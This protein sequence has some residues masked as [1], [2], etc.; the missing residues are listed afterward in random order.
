MINAGK[1]KNQIRNCKSKAAALQALLVAATL[2]SG[3]GAP[4]GADRAEDAPALTSAD[5]ELVEPISA[6]I[7]SEIATYR[8]I[9]TYEVLSGVVYPGITEYAFEED[10]TLK[11]YLHYPGEQVTAGTVLAQAN[12]D[13]LRDTIE[14]LE[15]EIADLDQS[16]RDDM[17]V[18]EVRRRN[19]TESIDRYTEE[20]L[21]E[22]A[23]A[24]ACQRLMFDRD[25]VD[26]EVQSRSALYDLDRAYKMR[27]LSH[28][29]EQDAENRITAKEGG[30]V[31]AVSQA[32]EGD[33]V[34]KEKS[35]VAT[36]DE[37]ERYFICEYKNSREMS[38]VVRAYICLRGQKYEVEY[39][40]YTHEEYNALISAGEAVHSTFRILGDAEEIPLGTPGILVLITGEAKDALS[41]SAKSIHRD[42][43]GYY[44]NRLNNG[45]VEKAHVTKGYT[46]G[47][48]T[49]ITEGLSYGDE[50]QL[51]SYQS[52]GTKTA[53]LGRGDFETKYTSLGYLAY[54]RETRI[55]A[56]LEY[57]QVT[58][59]EMVAEKMTRVAKGDVIARISVQGDE[60]AV[61]EKQL[62][63][64]RL[65]EKLAEVQEDIDYQIAIWGQESETYQRLINSRDSLNTQI[66]RL[67]KTIS[68]MESCY[69]MT[70]IVAPEDGLI[71]KVTSLSDGAVLQEGDIL[72][73]MVDES[74]CY[75]RLPNPN[76]TLNYGNTVSV[77]YMDEQDVLFE[78]EGKVVTLGSGGMTASMAGNEA[79]LELPEEDLQYIR[80]KVV[81]EHPSSFMEF[82]FG[83]EGHFDVQKNVVLVPVKAVFL[84]GQQTCVAVQEADGSVTVTSFI[85]GGR[86]VEYYWAVEGLEEGM[87]VCYE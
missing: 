60:I 38:E 33:M 77:H 35:V 14:G 45:V 84:L 6:S 52:Y 25:R 23:Q 30:I 63:L 24:I 50:I 13:A 83:I 46:D 29:R 48:Y 3:C 36:V 34:H 8:D 61:E 16:Y 57:G 80:E 9:V 18:Y 44:V 70:E 21:K 87:T 43:L 56:D 19:L 28:L 58:L 76:G 53:V 47:N 31:G 15:Q 86:D 75:L 85:A 79:Y 10:A 39:I 73:L 71:T 1:R 17:E 42:E 5:I 27:Q 11:G 62:A 51:N 81:A 2:L 26:L 69:R 22:D 74:L 49:Q 41:V 66:S 68:E 4:K 72:A 54:P 20:M 55:T 67:Q 37:T 12:G 32:A 59:V 40:P 65:Y 82:S 78:T 7:G 64:R